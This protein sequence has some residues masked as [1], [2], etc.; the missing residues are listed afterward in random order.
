MQD[1]RR[2][3]RGVI[4]GV[5]MLAMAACAAPALPAAQPLALPQPDVTPTP[6]LG[7]FHAEVVHQRALWRDENMQNYRIRFEYLEDATSAV[8]SYREVYVNNGSVRDAQCP[9]GACPIT[10][11]KDVKTISEV[12]TLLMR[13]PE[14]CI[15]Q[16]KYNRHLH[17]PEWVSADCADGVSQ[18]FTL[19]IRD[20]LQMQ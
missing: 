20:V 2:A 11:F 18:P 6:M 8:K 4:A 13:I 9:I 16:V 15:V 10:I 7:E 1:W 12:F 14:E 5:L 3:G 19:R 17:Y